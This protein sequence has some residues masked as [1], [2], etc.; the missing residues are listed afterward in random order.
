MTR[1]LPSQHSSCGNI[2]QFSS[3]G[4]EGLFSPSQRK[5]EKGNV[6]S[7]ERPARFS[8]LKTNRISVEY[9]PTS[10]Q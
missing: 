4:L 3:L 1:S 10:I 2:P 5:E 9:V 6:T 7:S 8:H